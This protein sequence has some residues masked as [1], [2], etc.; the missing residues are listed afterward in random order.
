MTEDSRHEECVTLDPDDPFEAV[1]IEMV[2]VNRKKRASY[3]SAGSSPWENFDRAE[4]Q[5][6]IPDGAG[7]EYMIATKQ[8]R[9]RA[10]ASRGG[11]TEYES[12]VDT[13][14]DRAVYSIIAYAHDR[15]PEG[16]VL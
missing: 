6:Q 5:V 3:T 13:K 4:D 1:L 12:V 14:L 16:K 2:Q 11:K 15:Y 9:L 10:L 8:A 7:I